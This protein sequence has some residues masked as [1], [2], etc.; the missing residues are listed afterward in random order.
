MFSAYLFRCLLG[1]MLSVGL[2][3][4]TKETGK[5]SF[6]TNKVKPILCTHCIMCHNDDLK[7]GNV[8]FLHRSGLLAAGEHGAP[9][10]PG[11]PEHSIL[12]HVIRQDGDVTM[13]PG[14]KL[15]ARDIA[16]LTE[17]VKLGA[18]WGGGSASCANSPSGKGRTSERWQ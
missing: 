11:K 12:I 14:G 13:P 7:N 2:D 17:W 16:T 15:P 6:F 5:G 9:I 8:S 18:R 1:L 4:Q 10:V 3:A